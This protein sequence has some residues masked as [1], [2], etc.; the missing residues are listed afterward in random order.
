VEEAL[1]GGRFTAGYPRIKPA[2]LP[3]D[4]T[5]LDVRGADEFAAG[6][7]KGAK[8]IAYTRLAARL[9]EAPAGA[10]VFVHC[11]TGIRASLAS[12]FLASRGREVV[13]VDGTFAEIPEELKE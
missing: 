1:A 5:V 8:N 2:E 6:H 11:G 10:P 12:A 3:A 13:H 9:D 7:V 4:A